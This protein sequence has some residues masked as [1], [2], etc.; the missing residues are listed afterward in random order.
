[1]LINLHMR[2]YNL[3]SAALGLIELS[4][5]LGARD[6][7]AVRFRVQAQ[8]ALRLPIDPTERDKVDLENRRDGVAI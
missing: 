5:S 7:D 8:R 2:N 4:N 1:M 6:S 3:R